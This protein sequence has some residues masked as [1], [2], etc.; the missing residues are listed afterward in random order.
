VITE[1]DLT[2]ESLAGTVVALLGERERLVAMAQKIRSLAKPDAAR[3][4]ARLV[5]EAEE[6]R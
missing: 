1:K 2:T 3:D 5:F 4:L 6:T